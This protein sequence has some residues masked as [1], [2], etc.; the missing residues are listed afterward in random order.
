MAAYSG[1]VGNAEIVIG[2]FVVP[3]GW[4]ALIAPIHILRS[5][6]MSTINSKQPAI[7]G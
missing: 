5:P 6:K 1:A 3:E 7:C 2:G 4:T